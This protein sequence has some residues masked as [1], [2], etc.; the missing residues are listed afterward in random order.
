MT[1]EELSAAVNQ[2]VSSEFTGSELC[3][4]HIA[5]LRYRDHQLSVQF[6]GPAPDGVV[7][8]V[9]VAFSDS[10]KNLDRDALSEQLRDQV[11]VLRYQPSI[12][13]PDVIEADNPQPLY[14]IDSHPDWALLLKPTEG[15]ILSLLRCL[16]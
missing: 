3:G 1:A 15:L 10:E 7:E 14:I 13:A 16:D 4:G 6:S 2:R 11:P 5:E 12:H 8:S 9:F